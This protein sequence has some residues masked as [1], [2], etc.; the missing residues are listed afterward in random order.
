MF[1]CIPPNLAGSTPM[2]SM[3]RFLWRAV[4]VQAQIVSS[5][6]QVNMAIYALV[7]S[8]DALVTSIASSY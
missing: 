6:Q 4:A 7:T 2:G 5:R 1:G 8:S 3:L